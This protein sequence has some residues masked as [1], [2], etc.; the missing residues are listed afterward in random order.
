MKDISQR[1]A[2]SD[3]QNRLHKQQ[4]DAAHEAGKSEIAKSVLHNI[5]NVLSSLNLSAKLQVEKLAVSRSA[6]LC[7]VARMLKEHEADLPT[8]IRERPQATFRAANSMQNGI[9]CYF[10]YGKDDLYK[11]STLPEQ[12]NS[13]GQLK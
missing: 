13:F 4:V 1:R 12:L 11:Y 7:K 6:I 2:Q 3:L 5:G 8:F 10:N 9:D